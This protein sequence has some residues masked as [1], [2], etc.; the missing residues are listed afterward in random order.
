MN[1]LFFA[2]KPLIYLIT[3]GTL[4]VAD[5]HE[6]SK[7]LIRLIASA[8]AMKIPLIQIREKNLPAR[9]VFDLVSE[10]AQIT[11]NTATKILINDRADIALAANADGV[12]LT[13]DSLSAKVI[14][15]NFP[16]NFIVGVSAHTFEKA[17]RAERDGAD[18]IAYS[19]IFPTPGKGAPQ[20]IGRLREICQGLNPFPVIALGGIDEG[21]FAEVLAA[22]ASGFAAIRF[23]NDEN[24]LKKLSERFYKNKSGQ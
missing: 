12:H 17:A 20:G 11:S 6:K 13:A 5:F 23:L 15:E 14:R 22:G 19:P 8:A 10:A 4:T 21:N 2:A 9:M 18:F 3:D 7:S 1:S 16:D 24:N